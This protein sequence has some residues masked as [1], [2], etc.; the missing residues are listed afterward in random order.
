MDRIIDG[1]FVT[2]PDTLMLSVL[3]NL[4]DTWRTPLTKILE[5]FRRLNS[6]NTSRRK[7]LYGV[8][9]K[10]RA[11]MGSGLRE[12]NMEGKSIWSFSLT[13]DCKKSIILSHT[14]VGACSQIDF[15][16]LLGNHTEK[17]AWNVKSNLERV[18]ISSEEYRN[19]YKC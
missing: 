15:F 12:V 18:G 7:D 6:R 5:G 13:F 16:F 9:Q 10:V 2:E 14:R 8:C 17:F 19:V 4:N 11:C 1:K 3:M